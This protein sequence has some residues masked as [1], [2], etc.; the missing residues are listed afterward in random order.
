MSLSSRRCG[1]YASWPATSKLQQQQTKQIQTLRLQRNKGVNNNKETTTQHR[2]VDCESSSVV[3]RAVVQVPDDAEVHLFF[4][5][6]QEMRR[7]RVQTVSTNTNKESKQAI[8]QICFSLT[9]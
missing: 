4:L 9:I 2:P 7:H 8:N 5:F 1:K 6:P 3:V